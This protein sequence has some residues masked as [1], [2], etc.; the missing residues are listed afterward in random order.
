MKGSPSLQKSLQ[1]LYSQ[2][3]KPLDL[4][5]GGNPAERVIS[6]LIDGVPEHLPPAITAKLAESIRQIGRM[7]SDDLRVV[8]FGGGTGLSNIVGGDSRRQEWQQ[9]PFSG[10]KKIF[11]R[12]HSVVCITDDGG[13][14]GEL[15]KDL[16]LIALGDLRHVL[17]SSVSQANLEAQFALDAEASG[18]L[19]RAMFALFNYRF[20]FCPAGVEQLLEDTGARLED[21]PEALKV[22]LCSLVETL[23]ADPRLRETLKKPQCLGNLLLAAAIY[24]QLDPALDAVELA[25]SYQVIRTATIRGLAGL[26]QALGMH[27]SAVLPCSVTNAVL[28]VCYANGVAVTGE[29]KSSD[30]SRGYP[31]DRIFVRFCRTPFVLPEVIELVKEA[32]ILLFAPGSLYTSVIPIMQVPGLAEAVRN[33]EKALKLL[34]ANIWVQQGE[35]DAARDEPERKFH[36]SDLIQAYHRNIP[37][38]VRDLFTHVLSLDLADIPGSILQRYALEGKA[39]IYLDRTRI[40]ELG[41]QT[42]AAPVFSREQLRRRRVIQHDAE[43]LASAVQ[44]LYGLK[45][46]GLLTCKKPRKKLPDD[47]LPLLSSRSSSFPLPCQRYWEIVTHCEYMSTEQLSPTS[48]FDEKMTGRDRKWLMSRVI[49]IIWG[50]PDI[51]LDHLRYVRG[52]TLV[53]PSCWKRC[54]QWDNVFSFY[55]PADQRI[56]IRQ[57]QMDDLRRFEMAFL[58]ALGQSLLGNYAQKKEMTPIVASGETVGS[59]Y[60]LTVLESKH[61]CCFFTPT[62]LDSYLRLARMSPSDAV[63]GLYTRLVNANEGFTPPGLLF[64]LFYAWYLDNRFAPNI[65][66]KMSIMRTELSDLIPEQ[67]RIVER[68]HRLIR[69]FRQH[70]FRHQT[71]PQEDEKKN[72]G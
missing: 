34:V 69:F 25:A 2:D 47:T 40:S 49:E 23:F 43:A 14:T 31:V 65:E 16:P 33:N 41:F 52:I 64:G 51:S 6:L 21:I 44:A 1:S 67:I 3:L 71:L 53:E 66:Y 39:P 5:A 45:T 37:G 11:P 59:L 72:N 10:L 57:D 12:C 26:C 55:D 42:V 4:L 63:A 28:Q 27:P 17:L 70:V 7:E 24:Q 13:S 36:V 50:H 68:R 29:R 32:D 22:F 30:C 46:A 38:G 15:L 62:A 20:I 58:V 56:K 54:Q 61:L 35:T 60:R 8:V 9:G 48:G 18:K 19:A